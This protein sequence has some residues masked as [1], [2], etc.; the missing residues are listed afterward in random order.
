MCFVFVVGADAAPVAFDRIVLLLAFF[1]VL[2]STL[3]LLLFIQ[4]LLIQLS[5]VFATFILLAQRRIAF[6]VCA[7]VCLYFTTLFSMQFP[8]HRLAAFIVDDQFTPVTCCCTC[9]CCYLVLP[10]FPMLS[11][12]T[13]FQSSF[14][15]LVVVL[16]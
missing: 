10:R 9:H 5:D 1:F 13:F 16:Y 8:L 3:M 7:R 2:F 6:Y 4:Q 11:S 15:L 14:K 12:Y